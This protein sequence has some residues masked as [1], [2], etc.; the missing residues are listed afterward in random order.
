MNHLT[1]LRELKTE[2]DCQAKVSKSVY[3]LDQLA[4]A[5]T[6]VNIAISC[7]DAGDDVP[8]EEL[9]EYIAMAR[10]KIDLAMALEYPTPPTLRTGSPPKP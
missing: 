1:T 8:D 10:G 9:E 7:L 3:A 4:Q 2:M 5:R 6:V